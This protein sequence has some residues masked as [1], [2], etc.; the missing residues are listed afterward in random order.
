MLGGGQVQHPLKQPKKAMAKPKALLL[1]QRL[2]I[3]P[4]AK[5]SG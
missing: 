5:A 2:E 3:M 4:T 1:H